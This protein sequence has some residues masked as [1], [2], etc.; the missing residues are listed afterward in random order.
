MLAAMPRA[1]VLADTDSYVKWGA[2]LVD[3]A[4]DPEDAPWESRVAV[5]DG[6][7]APSDRQVADAL[8]DTDVDV[9]TVERVRLDGLRRLLAAWR[10][11]VLVL[12]VRAHAVPVVVEVLPRDAS[13]PVVVTGVAGICVPVQWYDVNLRRGA[14]VFV[15]HSHRER[16]D[17]AEIASRHGVAHEVALATLPFLRV[18]SRRP[19]AAGRHAGPA[20][21]V[22]TVDEGPVVFA[23]QS[24]VPADDAGREVVL[25][26]LAEAA[27]AGS[28]VHVKVRSRDGEVEAH[29]G[30]GDYPAL[31]TRMRSDGRLPDAVRVVEGP[32]GLHLRGASGFVT[33]GSSA[34][35]EAVAA[36]VPTIVLTDL[37]VD[38][39]HL[40]GVFVGSGL[41]GSLRDVAE[42]RFRTV[43][44]A[45]A[46]DN[47][48]H[49]RAEDDWTARV[50]T[51]LARR[52]AADLPAP[53]RVPTTVGNR[54]RG[55]YYRLDAVAPWRGT[56][57]APLER[58]VLA[59]ARWVNRTVLHLR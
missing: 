29:R 13:R 7:A 1:L 37:G 52:A 53:A 2:T 4:R 25:A 9:A 14:D 24:L 57:L 56:P 5:L 23:P 42:R 54:V 31:M 36:D 45:W 51:L 33:I 44:P 19:V 15:V 41:L 40:N 17:L 49:D 10:P 32:M 59:A 50:E 43:D 47:Y 22:D 28:E 16:R 30:A 20:R 38:D 46:N 48:F 35:L 11:D 55:L 6:H 39:E 12:A 21:D 18:A 3:Q 8:V 34:A 27:R 58:L 26:G